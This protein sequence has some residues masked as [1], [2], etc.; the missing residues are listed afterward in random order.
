MEGS[1]F[2]VLEGLGIAQQ[3]EPEL[4]RTLARV[5]G[6]K[7]LQQDNQ[8]RL[9]NASQRKRN[10]NKDILTLC[11]NWATSTTTLQTATTNPIIAE[12]SERGRLSQAPNHGPLT[13]DHT[14][15]R[16]VEDSDFAA[17]AHMSRSLSCRWEGHSRRPELRLDAREVRPQQASRGC[18]IRYR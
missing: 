18:E 17:A 2:P 8:K 7:L 9:H 4:D 5:P 3:V 14:Q 11:Q 6:A 15:D 12:A 1:L 10:R 13:L 16:H